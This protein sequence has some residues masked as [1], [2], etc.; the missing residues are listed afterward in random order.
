MINPFLTKLTA[1]STRAIEGSPLK[2]KTHII[3]TSI[4]RLTVKII[5]IILILI[6][7]TGL[8]EAEGSFS[9]TSASP[10]RHAEGT[11]LKDSRA[12]FGM[13]IPQRG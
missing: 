10:Y 11:K 6:L 8:T 13:T 7:V 5:I 3:I 9:I 1:A 2:R 12:K 4:I